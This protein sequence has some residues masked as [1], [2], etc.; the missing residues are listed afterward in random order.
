ME[1]KKKGLD[2]KWVIAAAGFLL[3]FTTLGFC[4]GINGLYLKAITSAL[5]IPRGLYAI[6]NSC[7][8]IA[9]TLLNL[10]FGT[11]VLRFGARKLIAAGTFMLC[12]SC[13]LYATSNVVWGF[14]AA[15][16]SLGIG[17]SWCTTAMVGHI[18]GRWFTTNRGT[19]MGVI[20]SANGFGS[21]VAS[22]IMEPIIH[23]PGNPFGYRRAY[24]IS[25]IIVAAVGAVVVMLIRDAPDGTKITAVPGEKKS[26]GHVWAGIPFSEVVKKPM[27]YLA[28]LCIFF[29]GMALQSVTGVSAAHLED[30][31]MNTRFVAT[32]VS[33]SS[34]SLAAAKMSAGFCHDKL[35]LKFTLAV[36]Y[37]LGAIGT[38]ILA[39]VN[40][41]SYV[42]AIA[43][44]IIVA[45]SLP[46]ETIMIPLIAADLFGEEPYAKTLGIYCAACT[47]GFAIGGPAANFVFDFSGTYRGALIFF[48]ALMLVV[49]ICFN[50][51]IVRAQKER[52]NTEGA[53]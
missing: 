15:G 43:Y 51:L 5:D 1:T 49:G 35:G 3:V 34:L 4:S 8:Y 26:K 17:I 28:G 48:G 36:E 10:V 29:S 20:L 19:V 18:V 22:Q 25:L 30:V 46:I 27:F 47:A 7:R 6:S 23:M 44:E 13:A 11:L 52:E 33:V 41:T 42:L 40:A 31:G 21:A 32:A 50:R 14:Y 2:Y 12:V 9:T 53:E 16:A 38:F 24:W 45:F 37:G 39:S